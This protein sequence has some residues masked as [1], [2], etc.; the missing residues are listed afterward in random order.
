[1]GTAVS[2]VLSTPAAVTTWSSP[3]PAALGLRRYAAAVT[4]AVTSPP[5]GPVPP[6]CVAVGAGGVVT[7]TM[8]PGGVMSS[9]MLPPSPSP[10]PFMAMSW[11]PPLPLSLLWQPAAAASIAIIK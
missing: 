11:A 8:S 6:T 1:M 10:P 5:V 3:V 2:T 7:S 4:P 9:P